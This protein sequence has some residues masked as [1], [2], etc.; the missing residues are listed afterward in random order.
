M[1]HVRDW[2]AEMLEDYLEALRAALPSH[3]GAE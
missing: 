3:Q 2:E 1:V